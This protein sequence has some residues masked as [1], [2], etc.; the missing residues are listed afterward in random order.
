MALSL[1]NFDEAAQAAFNELKSEI[2]SSHAD[3]VLLSGEE[4]GALGLDEV[5]KLGRLLEGFDVRVICYFRPQF[6]LIRAEYLE[7]LKQGYIAMPFS[8]FWRIYGFLPKYNYFGV[9]SNWEQVFGRGAIVVRSLNKLKEEGTDVVS[10]VLDILGVSPITPIDLNQNQTNY[11]TFYAS[12]L[13]YANCRLS[14]V[15]GLGSEFSHTFYRADAKWAR[16]YHRAIERVIDKV[17]KLSVTCDS[18]FVG[19][20]KDEGWEYFGTRLDGNRELFDAIGCELWNNN[21]FLIELSKSQITPGI[22]PEIIS[23]IDSEIEWAVSGGHPDFA[24][25]H[26]FA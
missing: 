3:E 4:F 20:L 18:K 2:D 8:H 17:S 24:G 7:A 9:F 15:I 13:R 23:V 10:D 14:S 21:D 25:S 22:N 12:I 5:I 11:S 16:I 26:N 6:E 1:H 19:F